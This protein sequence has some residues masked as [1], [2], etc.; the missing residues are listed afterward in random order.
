MQSEGGAAGAVH[1]ALQA[2]SLSTTFTASQG[3]LL[4]IPNLYKI[5]GELTSYAMHVSARTIA[6]HALSIFGDHSDVM[7][8]RQTGV[9]LLCSGSVQEAHDFA[10]ISQ[11]ATLRARVP[12]IHFFDGFR[13]S[14][15][16]AKIEELDD[17]DLRAL[18]PDELIAAHRRRALSPDY[19]IIRGTAQ[20]PDAFFQARE[21]CNGFYTVC[22]DIVQETMDAFAARVGRAY[23][24]FDYVGHPQ[25]ERV[26]V[27]MGSGAEA[28]HEAVN[29]L[30]AAG[31]KVGLLK[32][33]LYR[34]FSIAA[35]VG[36][37]PKTVRSIAV[38]DRTKEPGGIGEPLYLDVVSA[39]S[40][41]RVNGETA[42]APAVIGGRYGLSSK[43]FTPAQVKAVFDELLQAKPK[44]HFTVGIMDDVTHLSL[45]VD[46]AFETESSQKGLVRAVFFGLGSDGTVGANKN[47]IKIIG[48]ETDNFAQGYFVYD[49]KKAGAVTISHLRFGPKPIQSSYLVQRASFVACHQYEFMDKYDVLSYAEPGAV[50]L[51]NSPF[52]PDEIWNEL[53]EEV[54]T[55]ILEKKLKFYVIDGYTVARDAG[56]SNRINTIMQTCFFAISGVLPKDEAITKI[57]DAIKKTYGKRGEAVVQANYRAVDEIAG[58]PLSRSTVPCDDQRDAADAAGR[59]RRGAGLRQAR[60]RRDD[61]EQG[62]PAPGQRLPGG[63]HVA[64]GHDAV[65]E[66]QHRARDPGM[67]RGALHPVQQVRDGLS[68]RRDPRQG[69]PVRH[70]GRRAGDVQ[71]H[72]L[73]GRRVQ[74]VEVHDP[75]CA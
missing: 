20:N 63:R 34:P 64:H 3:L 40:E 23:H 57:K 33:R 60:H 75:D 62:R 12:F 68:A 16:V 53:S 56:M 55:E 13:T 4:M 46:T 15:E 10:L 14:H 50:F 31:E 25:A 58:A 67:G 71:V 59:E 8:C 42:L 35:F 69:V 65:G 27:M 32:V 36:A 5:A 51:L 41:A 45:T 44:L 37:L 28:A 39:L 11:A 22:P 26:I 66:A 7:A 30:V 9:A 73:Q 29:A 70:A 43:E 6:T 47:S 74:G 54:Q 2:G 19:P 52:G 24:L 17:D 1:G 18:L 72:R 21:A 49:S 38:L 61:G 48:E